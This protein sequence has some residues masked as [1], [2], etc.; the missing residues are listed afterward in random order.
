MK[1]SLATSMK[2]K[3]PSKK[4]LVFP[5]THNE[6]FKLHEDCLAEVLRYLPLTDVC[7]I[8]ETD[9]RFRSAALIR[10][11]YEKVKDI[12]EEFLKDFSPDIREEFYKAFGPRASEIWFLSM[13]DLDFIN[14]IRHFRNLTSLT[15]IGVSIS[16]EE[17]DNLEL[18]RSLIA[19]H[20]SHFQIPEHVLQKWFVQV[21][22]SLRSLT[23]LDQRNQN[24]RRTYKCLE[25][26]TNITN[27]ALYTENWGEVSLGRL[28]EKNKNHLDFLTIYKGDKG[29][30]GKR[31]WK[32]ISELRHLNEL[33]ITS[34]KCANLGSVP[35]NLWPKLKS[36]SLRM[37]NPG[38]IISQLGC[39]SSLQTLRLDNINRF[40]DVDPTL[41]TR[42]SNLHSLQLIKRGWSGRKIFFLSSPQVLNMVANM[43]QLK[44]LILQHI[45]CRVHEQ[46]EPNEVAALKIQVEEA[47]EQRDP[48]LELHVFVT[49]SRY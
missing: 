36:L 19:L 31:N 26:L 37:D 2:N 39:E 35:S 11:G 28:I 33:H 16:C 41:L 25:V 14:A 9:Q 18:P 49:N 12:S 45:V 46:E 20:L 23:I 8:L 42:F 38:P 32:R 7:R 29:T 21:N 6:I 3:V 40:V 47:L 15:L 10:F 22:A 5:S 13:S 24:Q 1:K 4:D 44:K 17:S 43:P 30:L 27:F 34:I 48:P